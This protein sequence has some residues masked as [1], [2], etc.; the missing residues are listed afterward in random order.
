M[1][2][3]EVS[4]EIIY[5]VTRKDGTLTTTMSNK[6]FDTRLNVFIEYY[7]FLKKYLKKSDFKNLSISGRGYLR[8]SINLGYKKPFSVYKKLKRNRLHI[9][10]IKV[11]NPIWII[12]RWISYNRANNEQKK[13]Y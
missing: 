12:R 5:C 13:Y 9:F 4:N 10:N 2:K 3:F 7:K 1:D 6:V 8:Q 11:L